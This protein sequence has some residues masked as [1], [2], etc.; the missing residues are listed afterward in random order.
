MTTERTR[1]I[2]RISMTNLFGMYDYDL[3]ISGDSSKTE[4][5]FILYGDNGSGKTTILKL[6]FHLLAPE[7]GQSHKSIAVRIP[8]EHFE[9]EFQDNT[10]VYANR[11]KGMLRGNFS[12]GIK[13]PH[14]KEKRVEFIAN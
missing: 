2:R 13:S 11:P 9:I 4:K 14:Q 6:A 1:A 5:M 7:R 8:F 3:T 12:M 10:K